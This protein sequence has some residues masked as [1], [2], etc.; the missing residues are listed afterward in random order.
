[1]NRK[2]DRQ[3][4]A[5]LANSTLMRAAGGDPSD[6]MTTEEKGRIM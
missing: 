4:V 1:M 2:G 5:D 6:T 3:M